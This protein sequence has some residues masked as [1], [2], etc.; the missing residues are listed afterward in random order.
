MN[1]E[2]KILMIELLLHNYSGPSLVGGKNNVKWEPFLYPGKLLFPPLYF[3]KQFINESIFSI[4]SNIPKRSVAKF[5][6]SN[7]IGLQIMEYNN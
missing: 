1:S 3:M 4:I 5:G 7:F 6:G 2:V